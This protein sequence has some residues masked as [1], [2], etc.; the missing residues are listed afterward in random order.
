L[1]G[2]GNLP[3]LPSL[4]RLDESKSAACSVS[5]RLEIFGLYCRNMNTTEILFEKA[6]DRG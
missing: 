5:R 4:F 1:R 3:M 2:A 6:V